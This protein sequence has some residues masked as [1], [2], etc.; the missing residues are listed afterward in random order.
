MNLQHIKQKLDKVNRFYSYL[1]DNQKI[2]SR[3]DH[4]TFLASIRELYDACFDEQLA[5]KETTI[6]TPKT[7]PTSKQEKVVETTKKKRPKLVF[8]STNETTNTPKS[9]T[10]QRVEK[11]TPKKEPKQDPIIKTTPTTKENAP[12]KT[13]PTNE[14]NEEFE[15]LFLFK[16]ATDL[17]QKLSAA[18]LKDL[19]KAL[20]L[21]EKFLYIN[22][23]FGGD[24]AKFQTAIKDLNNGKDFDYA[25]AYIENNLIGQQDWLNKTKKTIAKDFIKLIRRRY[26]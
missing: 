12:E 8:N 17:S 6:A 25:R 5:K 11:T 15:E 4:D 9:S 1:E 20:G 7:N 18:P 19:N 26:L 21:N 24:V 14:F 23:L 22:E 10:S 13:I 16:A 3:V 2:I